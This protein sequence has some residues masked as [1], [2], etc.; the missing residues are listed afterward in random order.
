MICRLRAQEPTRPTPIGTRTGFK[1]VATSS[2]SS[3]VAASCSQ[4]DPRSAAR[5]CFAAATTAPSIVM[6]SNGAA[7][8]L[9]T[10][11][12][13][14]MSRVESRRWRVRMVIAV[15]ESARRRSWRWNVTEPE[16][17][18]ATQKRGSAERENSGQERADRLYLFPYDRVL[19]RV[20]VS[21]DRVAGGE[22]R[23][24]RRFSPLWT[25]HLIHGAVRHENRQVAIRGG[26]L[27]RKT[28]GHWQIRR[29]S[30]DA[31]QTLG[32]AQPCVQCDGAPLR[33]SG[34]HDARRCHA[35]RLLARDQC[36]DLLLRPGNAMNIGAVREVG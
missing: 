34:D 30:D 14:L 36:L 6:R 28:I 29:Q 3:L 4:T 23:A 9:V 26:G 24:A 8:A 21:F 20:G 1:P 12:I 31:A 7:S 10:S 35:A 17:I 27:C 22:Q 32:M 19:H 15:I 11:R 13:V 25:Y 16:P 33:E 2:T 18:R 5:T